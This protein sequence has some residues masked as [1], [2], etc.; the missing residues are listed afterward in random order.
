MDSSKYFAYASNMA[1]ESMLAT[2][3]GARFLGAA[4]L[5]G[6]RLAFSRRSVLTGTGVA[7]IP[8]DPTAEVWG[9]LYAV[10]SGDLEQLDRKEGRG[11]AY[12]RC[13]VLVRTVDETPHAAIAYSV[14]A[15]E[16]VEIRPSEHYMR[17]MISGAGECSLPAGYIASLLDVAARWGIEQRPP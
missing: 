8:A 2:C 15:K 3:G 4:R 5:P 12:E 1:V 14:I 16:P 9:A 6:H 13:E 7:D 10:G 11:F 17:L